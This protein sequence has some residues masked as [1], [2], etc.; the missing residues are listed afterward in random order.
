MKRLLFF[1]G[2]QLPPTLQSRLDQ[3]VDCSGRKATMYLSSLR[4]QVFCITLLA[5]LSAPLAAQIDNLPDWTRV[6]EEWGQVMFCQRIYK[7]P[8]VK[9]RLYDFDMEQCN[10]A[11]QLVLDVVTGFSEQ[12]RVQ[13]KDQAEIHAYRLSQNTSDPYQS[14]VGCREYCRKLAEKK[15]S[16]N[17]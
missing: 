13:L 3:I 16:S 2:Q 6:K 7:M 17:E 8:V 5:L 1:T 12:D 9:S 10:K 11:E 4:Y 14:V 15:D